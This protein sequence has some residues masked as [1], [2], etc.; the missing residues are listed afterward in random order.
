MPD[1]V[2]WG[3]DNPRVRRVPTGP[4][5]AP[6]GYVEG[7][8]DLVVEVRSPSTERYDLA[9][10]RRAYATAGVPYYWLL[11]WR[12]RTA[13]VLTAPAGGD[14]QHEITVPWADLRWPPA[15]GPGSGRWGDHPLFPPG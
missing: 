1:L 3:R 4:T 13:L 12:T 9:T 8:P 15:G 10:K 5:G 7:A 14:Y 2:L 6:A 11:D